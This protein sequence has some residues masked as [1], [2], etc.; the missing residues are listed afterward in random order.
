MEARQAKPDKLVR[1]DMVIDNAGFELFTDL[2]LVDYLLQVKLID[3]AHFH[4]KAMPW[5]VSDVVRHDWVWT[6]E[7]LREDE[8][9]AVSSIGQRFQ[10]RVSSG[11]CVLHDHHFWTT[12]HEYSNMKAVCPELYGELGKSDLV[13]FKGDLNY[14]KLV[15]DRSWPPTTPFEVALEGFHPAPLCTLRTLKADVVV[16]L[17]EGLAEEK[18]AGDKDWMVTG[19][20]A[21]I[22]FCGKVVGFL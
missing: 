11:V 3:T 18:R 7:V 8:A 2:I 6:L 21:V 20:N 5:F 13:I 19:E 15:A 10:D 4:M 1:L 17:R 12:F 16:G 14:R 9:S 22:Q